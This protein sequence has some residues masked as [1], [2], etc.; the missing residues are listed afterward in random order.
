[1]NKT[2]LFILL[3][4]LITTSCVPIYEK[5]DSN[6][7]L[8]ANDVYSVIWNVTDISTENLLAG[9]PGRIIVVGNKNGSPLP[10]IFGLESATGEIIW[11]IDGESAGGALVEDDGVL[12]RGRSGFAEVIAYDTETGLLLWRTLLPAGHSVANIV[13][14]ADTVFAYTNNNLFFVLD[15]QGEI[16]QVDYTTNISFFEMNGIV[17]D[18]NGLVFEAVDIASEQVVWQLELE[19]MIS[20]SPIVENDKIFFN[21][22]RIPNNIYSLNSSTG[23]V[24]WKVSQRTTSNILMLNDKIIFISNEDGGYLVTIDMSTGDEIARARFLPGFDTYEN[25][26]GYS[27]AGD[28]QNNIVAIAFGDNTQLMGLKVETP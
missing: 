25:T 21:T 12:Y 18:Q 1:M 20:D 27:I 28:A 14:M 22:D 8:E 9:A 6:H 19:G 10:S 3:F 11:Q 4:G 2:I 16:L 13:V 23:E 24:I 7:L 5:N 15:K 26:Y 17:Y